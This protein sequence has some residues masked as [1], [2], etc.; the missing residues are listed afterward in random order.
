VTDVET[1]NAEATP[2]PSPAV[3]LRPPRPEDREAFIAAMRDSAELHRPW[4]TPPVTA[5]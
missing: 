5:P 1:P 4:V 3:A 2:R